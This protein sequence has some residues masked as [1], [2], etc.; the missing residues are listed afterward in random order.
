MQDMIDSLRVFALPL[1][2]YATPD[3][4]VGLTAVAEVERFYLPRVLAAE[5]FFDRLMW[6]HLAGMRLGQAMGHLRNAEMVAGIGFRVI[7]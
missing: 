1:L 2:S 4:E 5:T 6:T 7:G 3:T